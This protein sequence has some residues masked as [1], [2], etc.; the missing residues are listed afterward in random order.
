VTRRRKLQWAAW[1]IRSSV[2][3]ALVVL[4]WTHSHWSVG[5]FAALC[6]V[7]FQLQDEI[8]RRQQP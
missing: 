1:G 4:I 5:L 8:D 7:R 3:S 6:E 2:E